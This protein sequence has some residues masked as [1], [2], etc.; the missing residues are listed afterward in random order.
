MSEIIT[1][2]TI[3]TAKRTKVLT[4]VTKNR[5]GYCAYVE[6]PKSAKTWDIYFR[7]T[8]GVTWNEDMDEAV[9][10]PKGLTDGFGNQIEPKDGFY[11]VG[12]DYMH[13]GQDDMTEKDVI[14]D[15]LEVVQNCGL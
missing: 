13:Y 15:V 7:C 6:I 14:E 11:V 9:G 10:Y 12:W 8:G 2:G 5:L 4:T 3:I 1:Q